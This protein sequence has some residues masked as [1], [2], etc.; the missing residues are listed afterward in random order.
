M[1]SHILFDSGATYVF[2]SY[3]FGTKLNVPIKSLDEVYVIEIIDDKFT[4]IRNIFRDC[5]LKINGRMFKVNL[6]PTKIKAFDV[7]IGMDCLGAN[8]AKIHFG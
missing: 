2:T 6:L 4:S 5:K 3:E 7:V 1:P 8:Q